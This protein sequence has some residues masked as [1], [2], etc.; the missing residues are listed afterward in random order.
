MGTYNQRGA[1]VQPEPVLFPAP[2]REN[3][4]WAAP[5]A[6]EAGLR[7]A[8]EQASADFV[9]VLPEGLDTVVGDRGARLSG[10][11]RQRIA[12]ARGLLR[13]PALLILDEVTSALD[14]ANEAAVTRAIAGLKGR[15]TILVI[16]HRGPLSALAERTVRLA[17]GQ[18]IT[19]CDTVRA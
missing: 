1:S 12:L 14:P 2:I 17:D 9:F 13:R 19:T 11:E 5:G 10:G 7:R 3:R 8:L 18:V 6:D 4:A 16:G 15:V